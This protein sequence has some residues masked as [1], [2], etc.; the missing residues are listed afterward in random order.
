MRRGRSGITKK[1]ENLNRSGIVLRKHMS[2]VLSLK[3]IRNEFRG[4]WLLIGDPKLDDELNLIAGKVLAHSPDRDQ[5]YRQLLSTCGKSVS[6][7]YAGDLPVDLAVV[8]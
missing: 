2:R 5:I 6:I 8:L 7:E 3:Q 1:L 4:E